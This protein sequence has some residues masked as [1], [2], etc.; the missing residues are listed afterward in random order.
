MRIAIPY[1]NEPR[2]ALLADLAASFADRRID[3]LWEHG[4][5]LKH[6]EL[7]QPAPWPTFYFQK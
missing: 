4:L 3:G 2:N 5:L 6:T 1:H 7:P